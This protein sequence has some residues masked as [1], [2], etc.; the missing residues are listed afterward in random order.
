MGYSQRQIEELRATIDAS[1]CDVVLA[2]TPIDL[3]RIV[4]AA[5]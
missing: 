3:R 1:D 2:G 4:G 5:C